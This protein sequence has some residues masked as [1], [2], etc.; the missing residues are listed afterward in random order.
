MGQRAVTTRNRGKAANRRE[1]RTDIS[2]FR[3]PLGWVG[4]AGRA[5]IAFRLWFGHTTANEVRQRIAAEVVEF[6]ERDWRPELRERLTAYA[7]GEAVDFRD[8]AV[9]LDG[10]TAFQQRVL[11]ALRRVGYGTT[12]S[13]ADLA[14]RAG[15]PGAARAVGQVMARNPLP[16]II[17]CHRVLASGGAIG[18]G[19]PGGDGGAAAQ[20]DGQSAPAADQRPGGGGGAVGRMR[21]HTRDGAATI[22]P[23]AVMSPNFNDAGTTATIAVAPV[24]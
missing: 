3:T 22:D 7:G 16:I 12:L 24:E 21:F 9:D 4:L 18:N 17:P 23:G 13:Y 15:S 2:V 14:S 1:D 11:A 10:W 8:V 5:G 19:G 20:I 6:D